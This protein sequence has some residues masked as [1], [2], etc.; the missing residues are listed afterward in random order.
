MKLNLINCVGKFLRNPLL[1][2]FCSSYQVEHITDIHQSISQMDRIEAII[3]KQKMLHYPKGQA[4]NGVQL[5]YEFKHRNADEE[6][7]F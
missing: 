7:S 4:F 3:R 5:E 6:V 2:T 1:D